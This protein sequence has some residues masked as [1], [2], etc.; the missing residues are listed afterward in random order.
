MKKIVFNSSLPRSGS[1]LLQNLLAQNPR[2]YCTPTSGVID[3][4]IA[5]R[6][7][8]TDL[9]EF[10]AQDADLVQQGFLGFCA[11]GMQGYFDGVTDKPICIDKCRSWFHYHH[12]ITR[13]YP[14]P[15]YLVCVRDLRAILSSMEKLWRKN[16]DR[17]DP[18]EV[19]GTLNMI[20]IN[21]RVNR[22][23]N[24]PPVGVAIARL[25]EA[26]QTGVVK[27]MHIIRFED[28]TETPEP[29]MRRIYEYLEEPYFEH[30]F[31]AVEQSTQ[32][33]DQLHTFYGD[34]RIRS[35][36]EPPVPDF[37]EILGR[38]ICASVKN[39][40]GLFYSTFYADKR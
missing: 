20:T 22:W 36:V 30:N 3:L 1:T 15:K 27:H 8:Y 16:R 29:V 18:D 14:N 33:N 6:K 12:W 13:F 31:N 2:M 28:L 5:G 37:M 26:I 23:L 39:N 4:L 21:N 34:H 38:D 11:A 35:K 25:I 10:K 17:S 7:F 9:A 19:T 40:Y 32:E 24:G